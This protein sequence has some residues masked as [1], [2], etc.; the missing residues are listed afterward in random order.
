M[1]RTALAILFGLILTACGPK[2]PPAVDV[3][4]DT[5]ETQDDAVVWTVVNDHAN[6]VDVLIQSE[7]ACGRTDSY[8]TVMRQVMPF[9]KR[10]DT[11]SARRLQDE[12]LCGVVDPTPGRAELPSQFV[13]FSIYPGVTLHMTV[14]NDLTHSSLWL[15]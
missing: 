5:I 3:V 11:L 12:T 2:I 9:S 7:Q 6:P 15:R 10:T 8:R 14:A 4:G 1:H 13:S